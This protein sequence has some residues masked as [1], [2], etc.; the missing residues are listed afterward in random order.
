MNDKAIIR[1]GKESNNNVVY[2][3][4]TINYDASNN[5]TI[6]NIYN[7]NDPTLAIESL[8]LTKNYS[9]IQSLYSEIVAS[10]PLYPHFE[11]TPMSGNIHKLISDP[12]TEE[13]MSKYP[14]NIKVSFTLDENKYP[15]YDKA[16]N[17]WEYAY[18]M[19]TPVEVVTS[20]YKE[21]LGDQEDPFPVV[22]YSDGMIMK[23]VAPPFPPAQPLLLKAGSISIE[24]LVERKPTIENGSYLIESVDTQE[25]AMHFSLY[26]A[27]NRK[28]T[29]SIKKFSTA[30]LEK[31]LEVEFLFQEMKSTQ[32]LSGFI[33]NSLLFETSLSKDILSEPAF[34][35][36]SSLI[37]FIQNLIELQNHFKCEFKTSLK[38]ITL[39]D[40]I[41]SMVMVHSLKNEW[42]RYNKR[43]EQKLRVSYDKID[44]SGIKAIVN[45]DSNVNGTVAELKNAVF[46]LSGINFACDS[47]F[48][49]YENALLNNINSVNKNIKR[50]SNNI[51]F[52]FK[53][54]KNQKYFIKSEILIG[55]RIIDS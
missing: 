6:N 44:A 20:E 11:A 28:S 45:G 24:I 2:Q 12:K 42:Y 48:M 1:L 53:P 13:A 17:P 26:L 23:I 36:N 14:K 30:P 31:I 7:I 9:A 5:V 54:I 52:S 43:S 33:V 50:R 34:N 46:D 22:E 10:H 25:S 35:S 21:Y 55:L 3:N 51:L 29:F 47:Y 37:N 49:V 18:R 8:K 15:N 41:L 38:E 32:K 19:Q 40:Y 4:S 39:D 16:E 27:K